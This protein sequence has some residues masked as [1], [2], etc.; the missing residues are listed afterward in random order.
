MTQ[1]GQSQYQIPLSS[2]IGPEMGHMSQIRPISFSLGFSK[3]SWLGIPLIN[4]FCRV[5]N[6]LKISV[7]YNN[8]YLFSCVWVY[9]T[10]VARIG[11]RYASQVSLLSLDQWLLGTYS[12]QEGAQSKQKH[13]I[14]LRVLAQ[15]CHI[16]PLSTFPKQVMWPH[17]TSLGRCLWW[18]QL[19]SL[20]NGRDYVM[21][22]SL[23]GG[24][25]RTENNNQSATL[26]LPFW[27]QALKMDPGS[28][29]GPTPHHVKLIW[30]WSPYPKNQVPRSS[31]L[32]PSLPSQILVMNYWISLWIGIL[33]FTWQET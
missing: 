7:A 21:Q 27:T 20:S 3:W 24:A 13:V 18:E 32:A 23:H 30:G 16:V 2:V 9:R 15:N 14:P 10:E 22:I 19:Q 28:C 17:P 5:T 12:S 1:V 8:R 25:W 31:G 4:Q 6:T 26:P 11:F 33:S 29:C